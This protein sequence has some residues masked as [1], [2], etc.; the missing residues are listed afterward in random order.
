MNF[1]VNWMHPSKG[2]KNWSIPNGRIKARVNGN[3]MEEGKCRNQALNGSIFFPYH[4]DIWSLW[5]WLFYARA[6][7]QFERRSID[8]RWHTNEGKP[9]RAT[10]QNNG[11]ANTTAR[12][13]QAYIDADNFAIIINSYAMNILSFGIFGALNVNANMHA[14]DL[15]GMTETVRHCCA[16]THTCEIS[17][18]PY[19]ISLFQHY[20][21]ITINTLT[22]LVHFSL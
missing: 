10:T 14:F 9:R 22:N 7:H 17:L 13:C 21:F 12:T 6:K 11:K 20:R 19:F 4:S 16:H 8:C 2:K 5:H 1:E 18:E 3:N 15:E